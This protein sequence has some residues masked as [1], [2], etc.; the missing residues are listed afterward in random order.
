MISADHLTKRFG[1]FTAIEDVS[2]SV[3]RG[4]IVGFLGPNGAG[5]STT[6]RILAGV[7]PPTF[8]RAVVAGYDVVGDS[9]QARS[10]VGYFPERISLY[11]DMTVSRYLG[12]VAQMKGLGGAELRREVGQAIESCALEPVASRL[13]GS[14]SKG[15]RQRVGIAQALVGSPRVL[16]LDEPTAGL[17]PEQVADVR[18]LVR[19]LRGERTVILSTHIL[20][21]VEATCDRVIIIHRGRIIAVDSPANLHRR[22]HRS[23]QVYLEVS[24]PEE[25][26]L[27]AVRGVAGVAG[28]E[29]Q[30]RHDGGVLAFTLTTH[31]GADPRETLA[32]L[33][34][35]RGWG[36]RELRPV[37]LSLEEIFLSLVAQPDAIAE[38]EARDESA[39][40]LQA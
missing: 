32:A 11:T 29:P 18:H 22:L 40:H 4:E 19:E 21:E 34:T 2:F 31:E 26:V 25:D 33:I 6:M 35:A 30:P 3:A 1:A 13:V 8:G 39:R 15:F 23:S 17:D 28:V 20:T 16:I 5:K 38:D 10:V 24:G 37:A 36:L 9:L 7:F 14:M 27:G 12:Y